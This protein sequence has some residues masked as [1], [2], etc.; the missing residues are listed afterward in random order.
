M[1]TPAPTDHI[2][3]T[4]SPIDVPA[5]LAH[6][7]AP[8]IGGIDLFL[9][10]TR[11]EHDAALGELLHLDYHAYEPMALAELQRLIAAV[12]Q[13]HKVVRC[14]IIHRLGPVAVGESSVL[15]AVGAAHRAAAFNAC[16]Q[17]IEGLKATVPIWKNEIFTNGTRWQ[18][19][20]GR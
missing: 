3:L 20:E 10:T 13:Q 15:I 9:G 18:H 8:T 6:V 4:R 5:A 19:P 17:L 2:S 16:R 7:T 12:R 11:S 14:A 1:T